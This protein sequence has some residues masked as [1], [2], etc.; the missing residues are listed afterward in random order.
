[1]LSLSEFTF[2]LED[3]RT[4]YAMKG[5]GPLRSLVTNSLQVRYHT[6]NRK[7]VLRS[8]IPGFGLLLGFVMIRTI[9]RMW[10]GSD[11]ESFLLRRTARTIL[12]INSPTRIWNWFRIWIRNWVQI[13]TL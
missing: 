2:I 10:R 11:Q 5:E 7:I 4:M 13:E 9:L 3:L 6:R 8:H 1:M 12:F